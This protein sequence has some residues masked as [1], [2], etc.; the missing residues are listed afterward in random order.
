M[1]PIDWQMLLNKG[2]SLVT[3]Y[4]KQP[5]DDVL[6]EVHEAAFEALSSYDESKCVPFEIWFLR[7][8]RRRVI[9]YLIRK[10]RE[11]LQTACEMILAELSMREPQTLYNAIEK[12]PD[13][14]KLLVEL[15]FEKGHSIRRVAKRLNLSIGQTIMKIDDVRLQI[16]RELT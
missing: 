10:R 11:R 7:H 9:R 13:D 5:D 3:K 14:G 12:L 6:S 2:Y 16:E 4:A 1:Q 15:R 8:V